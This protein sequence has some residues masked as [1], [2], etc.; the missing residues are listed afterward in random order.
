M[1]GAVSL[2]A[3]WDEGFLEVNTKRPKMMPRPTRATDPKE[4]SRAI[5]HFGRGLKVLLSEDDSDADEEKATSAADELCRGAG[6][7]SWYAWLQH[8]FTKLGSASDAETALQSSKLWSKL[9]HLTWSSRPL[10]SGSVWRRFLCSASELSA[11]RFP[12]D[13]GRAESLFPDRSTATSERAFAA[14]NASAGSAVKAFSASQRYE[15][16]ERSAQKPAGSCATP[17]R[18]RESAASH[19]RP[20]TDGGTTETPRPASVSAVM[21]RSAAAVLLLQRTP[22]QRLQGSV[23]LQRHADAVWAFADTKSHTACTSA[24]VCA[25]VTTAAQLMSSRRRSFKSIIINFSFFFCRSNQ[26]RVGREKQ[27]SGCGSGGMLFA[28]ILNQRG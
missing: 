7:Q 6:C 16:R 14:P 13:G 26:S 28:I 8:A 15:R 18:A 1:S 2:F 22:S 25:S 11:E 23:Q 10:R 12:K 3:A 20:R 24:A 17:F 27:N 9:I 19:E 5:A 21:C 4:T